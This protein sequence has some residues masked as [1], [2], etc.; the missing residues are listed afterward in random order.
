MGT[1]ATRLGRKAKSLGR[2]GLKVGLFAGGVALGAKAPDALSKIEQ[3]Y[4]DYEYEL[5]RQDEGKELTALML[6]TQEL[7]NPAQQV[8]ILEKFKRD[9]LAKRTAQHQEGGQTLSMGQRI[10]TA[11]AGIGNIYEGKRREG[12]KQLY[13]AYR[14]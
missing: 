2:L 3:K 12:L 9:Q 6:A 10:T 1:F 8:E 7:G 14:G 5:H 4:K 11:G 13:T